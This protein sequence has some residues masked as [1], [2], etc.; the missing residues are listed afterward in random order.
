[1]IEELSTF[2]RLEEVENYKCKLFIHLSTV[3]TVVPVPASTH[4]LVQCSIVDT[5][6]QAEI[7]HSAA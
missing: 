6:L 7:H 4:M 1:M 5:V 3:D 2:I